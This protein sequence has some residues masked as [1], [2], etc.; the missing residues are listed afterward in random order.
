MVG[1]EAERFPEV[2]RRVAAEGHSVGSHTLSH[3]DHEAIE[4]HEA[5]ADMLAGAEAVARVVGSE[6]VLYRAPYGCFVP[7]TVEEA[8]R[9]GWARGHWGAPGSSLRT[10]PGPPPSR[11]R[12]WRAA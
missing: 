5:V 12:S 8:E 7:A 6:P 3:L 1:T 10:Q 11:M 2:A 9:R 4:H